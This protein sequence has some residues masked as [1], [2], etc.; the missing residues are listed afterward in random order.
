MNG[1]CF[2]HR[3]TPSV[4]VNNGGNKSF[5]FLKDFNSCGI[6]PSLLVVH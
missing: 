2:Y 1:Y 6:S 5:A 3:Y 4:I